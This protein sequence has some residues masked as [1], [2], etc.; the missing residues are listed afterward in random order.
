MSEHEH[1]DEQVE[2]AAECLFTEYVSAAY[3]GVTLPKWVTCESAARAGSLHQA[4]RALDHGYVPPPKPMT[5]R[6]ELVD[7]MSKSAPNV[8][9]HGGRHTD[10][11]ADAILAR[12]DVT[13]KPDA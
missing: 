9:F 13:R 2:W 10:V 12:F 1:T 8:I 4:R 3:R 7:V 11:I 6:E 5:V